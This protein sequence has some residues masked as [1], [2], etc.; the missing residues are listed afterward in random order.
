[1]ESSRGYELPGQGTLASKGQRSYSISESRNSI[2]LGEDRDSRS[3]RVRDEVSKEKEL[4]EKRN[5]SAR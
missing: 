2:L 1:M 3:R 5:L 4:W